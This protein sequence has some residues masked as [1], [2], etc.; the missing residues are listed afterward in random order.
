MGAFVPK[1]NN[2]YYKTNPSDFI[3]AHMPFDRLWQLLYHPV[4]F[5]DFNNG[6]VK[7]DSGKSFF[8]FPDSIAIYEKQN[9]KKE[10]R[11]P[12]RG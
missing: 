11:P 2:A 3:Q 7:E 4:S 9:R 10:T 12:I 5:T 6:S 1:I 8:N